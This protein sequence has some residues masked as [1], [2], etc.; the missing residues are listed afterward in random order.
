VSAGLGEVS[1]VG[2]GGLQRWFIALV[3]A[4][5]RGVARCHRDLAYVGAGLEPGFG[6]VDSL[7]GHRGC[8][9]VDL[10]VLV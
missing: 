5:R 9:Y 3:R 1:P 7:R 10:D 8:A 6:P 4:R 2:S